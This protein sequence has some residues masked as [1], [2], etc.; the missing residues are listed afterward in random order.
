MCYYWQPVS[1]QTNQ[2]LVLDSFT[3]LVTVG[4]DSIGRDTQYD[5]R[6]G[7]IIVV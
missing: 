4:L 7:I 3:E 2:F 5:S 6:G 1:V